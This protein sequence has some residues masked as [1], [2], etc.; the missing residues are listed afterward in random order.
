M[1]QRGKVLVYV[2]VRETSLKKSLQL[3]VLTQLGWTCGYCNLHPPKFWGKEKNKQEKKK[4]NWS[5]FFTSALFCLE[6][7]TFI[8]APLI[9]HFTR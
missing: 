9:N 8:T 4:K 2:G 5:M 3:T 7:T 6:V 1:K